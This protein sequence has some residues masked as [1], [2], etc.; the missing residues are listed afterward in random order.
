MA[1]LREMETIYLHVD[2]NNDIACEMYRKAGYE[3]TKKQDPLFYEFT[4]SLSL[5]DGKTEGRSHHLLYKNLSTTQTWIDGSV[6]LNTRV[7]GFEA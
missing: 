6:T 4:Y 7:I 1:R 3:L 5:Q 2:V